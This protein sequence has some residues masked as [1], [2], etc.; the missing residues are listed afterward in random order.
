MRAFSCVLLVVLFCGASAFEKL[1]DVDFS[2]FPLEQNQIN[3][4]DIVSVS[5]T[6]ATFTVNRIGG[7]PCK[8][9]DVVKELSK[10]KT[11]KNAVVE[12]AAALPVVQPAVAVQPALAATQAASV[13]QQVPVNPGEVVLIV[14]DGVV[15][16]GGANPESVVVEQVT[17]DE[18]PANLQAVNS[19][20][21]A[22]NQANRK[23]ML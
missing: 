12:P 4:C 15:S 10:M 17:R 14:E 21:P 11:P 1:N 5:P 18:L 13:I 6:G 22:G 16:V 20:N 2:V 19:V 8:N 7:K 3:L 23:L 9:S